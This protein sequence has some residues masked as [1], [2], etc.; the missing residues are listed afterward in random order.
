[1]DHELVTRLVE[2]ALRAPSPH[3]SQPWR[4]ALLTRDTQLALGAAMGQALLQDLT[5]AGADKVAALAQVKRSRDR[6]A[7]APLALVCSTI[8]ARL[9]FSGDP[10]GDALEVAMAVQSVGAFLQTFFLL[11]EC[12]LLG[13]CWMAAP[14]YC[15]DV[16]RRVLGLRGDHHPQ[17]L[18]LMGYAAEPGRD[19]GRIAVEDVVSVR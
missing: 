4:I 10:N 13:T 5:T 12:E 6:I 18:V 9:N 17:A 16:V 15:A 3:N 11:A 1:V 7:A 19:R 8:H 2:G 14:M